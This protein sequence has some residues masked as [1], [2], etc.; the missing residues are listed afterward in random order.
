MAA[1]GQRLT[2]PITS[3]LAAGCGFGGSCFPKDV[4]ALIQWGREHDR[5]ARMLSAVMA[6]NDAQP[7][8][9]VRLLTRHFAS[10]ENVRVAVLGLAFKAGTDDVR[11]SPAL[12][13]IADLRNAGA[14]VVAFDPVA[15]ESAKLVLAD[16]TV[17]YAVSLAEALEGADAALLMTTWPDFQELPALLNALP[18]PPV[19]IDGRRMLDKRRI[20][21]YEGIGLGQGGERWAAGA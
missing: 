5:H 18:T 19:V 11:E 6:T 12:R 2:P 20:A 4:R 1:D 14:Q 21:R 3:Y 15:T 13:I 16:C 8:E 7:L 17:Q 9:V 10:L